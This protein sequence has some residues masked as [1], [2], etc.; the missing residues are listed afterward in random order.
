M[1]SKIR[2]RREAAK[3]NEDDGDTKEFLLNRS[4]KIKEGVSPEVEY[5]IHEFLGSGKFGD[6]NRCEEKSTG[7]E[8]AAKV[9]PYSCLDEKDGV[10]NEVGI[11]CRLRHPRL[12][13]LYDVFIQRD[14]ITLIMEL[15]TGGEL[16][17]RVIDDSFDLNEAIC[18]KFM[19][20]ILQGVEYIHSQHVIHL[21]LKPENIL[22]L[23]RTGFKI[24]I[25][26]FGLAREV[27]NGDL[28]VMFGTPEFVAPEVIAFDPVT[29]ATD[30]WSLGV[31]CY[32]LLSGLSPFM[33]DNESETL[34]NIMRCSY[35]FDYPEFKDISA[36]AKD[37]IKSLLN[38]NPRKRNTATQ[39]LAHPWLKEKPRLKRSATVNKKRLRHFVY[40]RKWQKA[41][42]A[43][44]AL[45][46]MGVVLTHTPNRESDYRKLLQAKSSKTAAFY[47]KTSIRDTPF[48]V[49]PE[50]DVK[51]KQSYSKPSEAVKQP[52]ERRVSIPPTDAQKTTPNK[53][54]P[55]ITVTNPSK[56]ELKQ[57]IPGFTQDQISSSSPVNKPSTPISP[58]TDLTFPS[59]QM[60]TKLAT[61]PQKTLINSTSNN[62]FKKE[63]QPPTHTDQKHTSP[64]PPALQ[65][66]N[67]TEVKQPSFGI[68]NKTP[69]NPAT[70]GVSSINASADATKGSIS[71]PFGN[72][73]LSL[74]KSTATNVVSKSATQMKSPPS[75]T[76]IRPFTAP[77]INS[78]NATAE[79]TSSGTTADRPNPQPSEPVLLKMVTLSKPR[80]SVADRI[81]FFNN[82]STN[83]QMKS[84]KGKKFSLYS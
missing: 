20:Q 78:T 44:I 52:I 33:G 70:P 46:R 61:A 55:Q 37:F 19:R 14:R 77:S 8:L 38:K 50:G 75:S 9:V 81:S 34:S 47:R 83:Q 59:G 5:R 30:M 32:V 26:D 41:V 76:T 63:A 62:P 4:V 18:E 3:E 80:G 48:V 60:Q 65:P 69:K 36:D 35:T 42:N 21:D 72:R 71:P 51:R 64:K 58:K 24:K 1:L 49:V 39:C 29:Y 12:I 57:R 31:V 13:Q 17:E 16:F 22:C 7:Y 45:Q 27:T 23:S 43:I 11:M 10:M 40:R 79:T 6:V 66:M 54:L 53:R 68:T 67:K 15:I 2:N 25:I 74:Q 56:P 82:S 73:E 28:R 84:T